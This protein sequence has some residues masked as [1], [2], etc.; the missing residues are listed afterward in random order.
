MRAGFSPSSLRSSSSVSPDFAPCPWT[1]ACGPEALKTL[2]AIEQVFV[3]AGRDIDE[4]TFNR[5]LFLARRR[6][7]KRLEGSDPV[8]YVPSLSRAPSSTRAW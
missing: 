3:N 8:F 4:A 1:R 7:E 2:P 5:K 6:T